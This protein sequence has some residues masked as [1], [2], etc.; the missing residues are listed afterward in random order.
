M[1]DAVT[2]GTTPERHQRGYWGRA[3]YYCI[4][5]FPFTFLIVQNGSLFSAGSCGGSLWKEKMDSR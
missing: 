4:F 3:M 1:P 2:L 5:L